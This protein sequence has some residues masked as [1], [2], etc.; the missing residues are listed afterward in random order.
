MLKPMLPYEKS[1][2]ARADLGLQA[3]PQRSSKSMLAGFKDR[4][5]HPLAVTFIFLAQGMGSTF[6]AEPDSTTRPLWT[7]SRLRGTPEPPPPYVVE[8]VFPGWRCKIRSTSLRSQER[9]GCLSSILVQ[10]I[11]SRGK[12]GVSRIRRT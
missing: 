11:P 12:S 10:K 4:V 6:A 3:L 2:H 1:G 9:T 7:T 5:L 8:K